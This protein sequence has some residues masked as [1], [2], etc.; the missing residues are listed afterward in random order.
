MATTSS[1]PLARS[2]IWLV[3]AGAAVDR[4]DPHAGVGGDGLEHLGHLD[5][6]LTRR[7]E[8]EAE[9]LAGLG[10]VGDAGQH[11]HAERE[12]LARSGLGPT[13]HVATLHRDRDRLG[14]DRE[15]L[16]ETAGGE[17]VVDA[18][19]HAEIGEPGRRLD[20]RQRV[21]RREV[22][23]RLGGVAVTGDRSV[24]VIG[25]PTWLTAPAGRITTAAG[26]RT[27]VIHGST[28]D[29]WQFARRAASP[30]STNGASECTTLPWR[31]RHT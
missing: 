5:G 20:R 18:L 26:P 13:A 14:L 7:H 3:P 8:H 31:A 22:A 24:V 23:D 15:R 28:Q 1:T 21:D 29:I 27:G 19:G 25:R 30:S 6:Q 17:A 10:D 9:R 2:S 12:R 4:Q 16:G 11:R